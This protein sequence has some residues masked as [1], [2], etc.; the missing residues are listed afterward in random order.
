[1]FFQSLFTW[2]SVYV[3][4]NGI[5]QWWYLEL[6]CGGYLEAVNDSRQGR[7]SWIDQE[8]HNRLLAARHSSSHIL[9]SGSYRI[10]SV[11][12]R[13]NKVRRELIVVV[14]VCA[15]RN[16]LEPQTSTPSSPLPHSTW[17]HITSRSQQEGIHPVTSDS[18]V[19]SQSAASRL[20]CRRTRKKR[21][22]SG[23][24]PVMSTPAPVASQCGGLYSCIKQS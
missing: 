18:L 12:G 15:I 21:T 14:L 6:G 22:S 2:L 7:S 23:S 11:N 19:C 4:A 9:E 5:V 17:I 3:L 16:Q 24:G 20:Y 10:Y 8:Q 1:M 13:G